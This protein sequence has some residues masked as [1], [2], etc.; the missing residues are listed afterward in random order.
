MKDSGKQDFLTEVILWLLASPVYFVLALIRGYRHMKFLSIAS[1]PNILCECG[2]EVSLVG[3]WRCHCGFTYRGHLVRPC[4]VDG[5]I[6]VMVR[7]YRCGVTTK[8]PEA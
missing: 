3:L 8:L 6:P 5:T 1:K 7:C 2:S 4:P